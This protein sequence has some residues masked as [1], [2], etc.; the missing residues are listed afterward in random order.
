MNCHTTPHADALPN[1]FTSQM[2]HKPCTASG[3]GRHALKVNLQS[4]MVCLR[5]ILFLVTRS[6]R[7]ATLVS[8]D[9]MSLDN[10]EVKQVCK[11][12]QKTFVTHIQ[13]LYTEWVIKTPGHHTI[14]STH[15]HRKFFLHVCWHMRS[16][17]HA[18]HA[19]TQY[20]GHS[21]RP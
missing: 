5:T 10:Q 1:S 7:G 16:F 15:M 11:L 13:A 19:T 2:L 9:A 14:W 3:A 6:H 20:S 21:R 18:R 17:L 8:K 4:R 12:N